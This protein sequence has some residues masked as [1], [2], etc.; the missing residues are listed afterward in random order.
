VKNLEKKQVIVLTL[1]LLAFTL[2]AI[3]IA[4]AESP[5]IQ[6]VDPTGDDKGPG[7][8]GYPTA[9]VFKPGVF[10]IVKFEIY[11]DDKTLTFKTYFKDLGGNPW[12][13]KNGFCLQQLHIYLHTDAPANIPSRSSTI[14]LN[15]NLDP[16]WAWHYAILVGPC[17]ETPPQPLPTGQCAVIYRPFDYVVQDDRL[18]V[19]VDGN[20][21][22]VQVDRG[23]IDYGDVGNIKN[24]RIIV[25]VASH[26]GFGPLK[27][28]GVGLSKGDWN[29]WATATANDQQKIAI[30]N[31]IKFGIEPRVM[32]IAVYSPEYPNG[33]SADQQYAWLS[34]FD[35]NT[36]TPAVIPPLTLD[37]KAQLASIT[38]ERDD[39][40]TQ[41]SSLQ[42]QVSTL[43]SQVN[44]LQGQIKTL[45]D[46]NKQLQDQLQTLQASTVST[47]IAMGLAIVLFIIGFAVG[48]LFTGKKK[49]SS[50]TTAKQS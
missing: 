3:R 31:A 39:L 22:V 41:V 38:K 43:Q 6:V 9:D 7:Y 34:S 21:I 26:D 30:A 35:P 8:Y 10:D 24:W 18:K 29:I 2:P 11:T 27:I 13:G 28:R 49:S 48:Y 33:I 37:L 15:V 20:A 45:Q 40:K 14:G 44:S 12:G 46:Q 1:L 5:V 17:W 4:R 23:L 36:K 25:A 16:T 19:S 42:G 47:T 50:G 32:D